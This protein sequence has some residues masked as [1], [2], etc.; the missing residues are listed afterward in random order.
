[1]QD[2]LSLSD[3]SRGLNLWYDIQAVRTRY[4]GPDHQDPR[5]LMSFHFSG[6]Y[7]SM[8]AVTFNIFCTIGYIHSHN[9]WPGL[10]DSL[11]L[12][13]GPPDGNINAFMFFALTN[14]FVA[15][16]C[17]GFN[18]STAVERLD[19][20]DA[21]RKYLRAEEQ[22]VTGKEYRPPSPPRYPSGRHPRPYSVD[23]A[24]LLVVTMDPNGK[25]TYDLIAE[26]NRSHGLNLDR[27]KFVL[28]PIDTDLVLPG[29]ALCVRVEVKDRYQSEVAPFTVAIR[30]PTGGAPDLSRRPNEE[31]HRRLM[32]MLTGA[33][34]NPHIVS[35]EEVG[36]G[37][38]DRRLMVEYDMISRRRTIEY[39]ETPMGTHDNGCATITR[40]C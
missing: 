2:E 31:H 24:T 3:V 15:V 30:I 10:S 13:N 7:L 39:T 9:L 4:L 26:V 29:A 16:F 34:R 20:E 22:L 19:A 40:V 36:I 1:M 14:A 5:Q 12:D 23:P 17:G 35:R 6:W 32:A 37:L 27:M 8:M 21:Y 18:S 38:S 33:P 11:G 28:A 25:D